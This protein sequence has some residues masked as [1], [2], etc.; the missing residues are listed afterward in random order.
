M[1]WIIT[2]VACVVLLAQTPPINAPTGL[3]ITIDGKV[4]NGFTSLVFTSGNGILWVANQSGTTLILSAGLNTTTALTR[5]ML[6]SGACTFIRSVNGTNSYTYSFG[7]A[8]TAWSAYGTGPWF[9]LA[10]TKCPTFCTLNVDN[11]GMHNIKRGDGTTDPGGIVDFT[12]GAWI[13]FDASVTG[14][15]VFKIIGT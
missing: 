4:M 6:Q 12:K 15:G 9:I 8:C 2:V 1:R 3:T 14:G 5:A 10:D 13:W 7:P 11:L